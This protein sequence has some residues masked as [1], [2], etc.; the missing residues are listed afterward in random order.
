LPESTTAPPIDVPVPLRNLVVECTTKV[1]PYSIGLQSHGVASVLS[2]SSGTPA[3]SAMRAIA[4]MSL[5]TPPG[6]AR[7]SMKNALVLSVT[8]RL[9]LS[10]VSASTMLAVHPNFG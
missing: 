3:S 6:F 8:A 4:S 5:M 2:T 1:A 10:G 7:L 9:K